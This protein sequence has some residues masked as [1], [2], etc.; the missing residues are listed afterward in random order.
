[1]RSTYDEHIEEKEQKDDEEEEVDWKGI[2]IG[3]KEENKESALLLKCYHSP[4][5]EWK[6]RC[7]EHSEH[8]KMKIG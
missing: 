2:V 8:L 1:M 3:K 4:S 5:I 7:V 6:N